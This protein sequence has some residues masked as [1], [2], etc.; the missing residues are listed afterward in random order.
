MR[1]YTNL[2]RHMHSIL[3]YFTEETKRVT[4]NMNAAI[5]SVNETLHQLLG[6]C[7]ISIVFH[8]GHT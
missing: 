4:F 2:F 5:K 3:F 1:L 7:A 8:Q 6:F